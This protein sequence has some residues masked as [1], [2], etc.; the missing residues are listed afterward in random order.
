MPM[1]FPDMASLI[2]A[3]S[4]HGF[5][6]PNKDE[7]EAAYRVALADHAE[8]I[9]FI[10]GQEI[11]TGKGWDQWDDEENKQMLRRSGLKLP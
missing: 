1:D 8:K 10:E 6:Q 4:I 5:R 7:P 3:A 9:D 11:R 2:R